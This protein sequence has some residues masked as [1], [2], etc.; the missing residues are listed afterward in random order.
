MESI[1]QSLSVLVVL[2][3]LGGTLWWLRTK[4][5]AVFAVKASG[6]RAK[7][8]KVIERVTLTPQH[9]LHL[10]R[11]AEKTMLI[12]T[13]PGGCSILEGISESAGGRMEAR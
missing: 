2:A 7:A 5:L 1:Q 8:M 11:V 3:L 12:A 13:S 6:G 4:G 10:V 9:S